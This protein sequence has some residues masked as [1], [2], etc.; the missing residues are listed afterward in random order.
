MGAARPRAV[1]VTRRLTAAIA[2]AAT[3]LV[4]LVVW[5]GA[6][7]AQQSPDAGGATGHAFASTTPPASLTSSRE[8]AV[9]TAA[10]P[11]GHSD[12]DTGGW[13]E[14]AAV[15]VLL[16]RPVAF[17]VGLLDTSAAAATSVPVARVRERSPPSTE[18]LVPR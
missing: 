16:A 6:A 2:V 5:T 9:V 17:F 1:D 12:A 11:R 14:P 15:G 10:S 3:M 8:Q 18:T 4:G 13:A 7:S